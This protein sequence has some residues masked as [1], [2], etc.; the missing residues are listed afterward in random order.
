MPD[1]TPRKPDY[2]VSALDKGHDDL[3]GGIGVGWIQQDGTIRLKLN[4]F[5]V[6]DTTRHELV[7]TL[8]PANKQGDHNASTAKSRRRNEEGV[9]ADPF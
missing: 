7:I 8:F 2:N 1:F 3:K 4:P 5:V 9:Q 6:L